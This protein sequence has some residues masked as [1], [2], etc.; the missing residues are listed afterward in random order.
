MQNKSHLMLVN[1]DILSIVT[2][3]DSK[4]SYVPAK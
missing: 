4:K 1:V 2:L 3:V